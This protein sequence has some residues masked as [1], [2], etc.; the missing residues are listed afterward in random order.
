MSLGVVL[1]IHSVHARNIYRGVKRYEYRTRKPKRDVSYIALYE[2]GAIRAITG[3][4][5]IAGILEGAPAMVWNLT[6]SF[7]GISRDYFRNYF[8]G[9]KKAVAY[10]ISEVIP[11]E[12][13][14]LLS[15]IGIERA[16]Q[17][18]QYI[19][20]N[21]VAKLLEAEMKSKRPLLP[22]FFVGGVHGVG[23]STFVKGIASE[24]GLHAYSASQ[25]ILGETGP[26]ILKRVPVEAAISN[27]RSLL[28]GLRET[29]W[30]NTGGLLD[31]HFVLRTGNEHVSPV[32]VEVFSQLDLD[33]MF[34]LTDTPSNI[35][36][37]IKER[38]GIVWSHS[39]VEKMQ[40][41]EV[42]HARVVSDRLN[43]PLS[44]IR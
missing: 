34:V 21:E 13:P 6:K 38:D 3:I 42:A 24:M 40:E 44:I 7:S 36:E 19:D 2:T 30:F 16:P 43:I 41:N 4:A 15:E 11:F 39:L 10:C 9:K 12:N 33:A 35:A 32:P 17:S 14:I 18:F 20:E 29:D 31:G 28:F 22:R 1:S 25:I 27:Q 37:R 5:K 23:K 8:L 26:D